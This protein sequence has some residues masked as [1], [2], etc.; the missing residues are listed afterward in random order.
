MDFIVGTLTRL[1]GPG[2][3]RI[4][5]TNDSLTCLWTDS[6]YTDPNWLV[7]GPNGH[8]FAV[9]SDAKG[10]PKG[11]INELEVRAGGLRL[12]AR[13]ET[14]GSAPCHITFSQD[15][16]FLL[17]TNYGSGSLVVYPLSKGVLE[18]RIQLVQCKGHSVHQV[19]QTAPHLHQI[20]HIP[21]L[22]GYFCAADLGTDNLIVFQQDAN[23]GL[24]MECYRL[25]IPAGEGPR[26][27]THGADGRSW[28]VTELGNKLYPI[29]FRPTEA[30]LGCGVATTETD[31]ENAAA[32]IRLSVDER[33]AFVSNRGE[34]SIAVFSL[35]PFKKTEV[36]RNVGKTPRDFVLLAQDRILAACQGEGVVLL[37]KGCRIDML[38]MPG[39]VCVLPVPQ[40]IMK[41]PQQE[42]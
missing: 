33:R 19:R 38:P 1:G 29:E 27:L 30:V 11:C 23:T 41:T 17:A 2:I 4:R 20:T 34:D 6:R 32:A 36:W 25:Q 16:R 35:S 28:L 5:L 18:P 7:F 3:A 24:L 21:S 12:L 26:H 31:C 9:S 14:G 40:R 10:E 15:G 42:R 22:S 39:A 13:Q 37:E 8:L